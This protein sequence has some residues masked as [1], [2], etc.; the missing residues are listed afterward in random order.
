MKFSFVLPAWKGK[1]L[2]EAI[3]SILS[4]TC[5][6]FELIVV[7]DCS[8]DPIKDI[9]DCFHDPRVSYHRN[10]RNIGGTDLVAQWM[11]CL[12]Y[13]H[14]D[15]VI[16]ATDDDL[17]EPGFLASME[18]LI[19][20]Y[21]QVHLFRSRM[22]TIGADGHIQFLDDCFKEFLTTDEFVYHLFHGMIRG[23][24][25]YVFH[26]KALLEK[27][28]FVNFPL[29]WGSDDATAILMADH[30][31]VNNQDNLVRFRWSDVN[32]SS[33]SKSMPRKIE[34][35]LQY[36]VW[37]RRHLRPI[38]TDTEYNR[39]LHRNIDDYWHQVVKIDL[40]TFLR[41]AFW[42]DKAACL[43]LICASPELSRH[44]KLSI[45]YHAFFYFRISRW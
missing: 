41:K 25:H 8:P 31:V 28:G 45:I 11:R 13:A 30:G 24:P 26:R 15:Y 23:I 22:M 43:R 4:Q 37:L 34:A 18:P 40:I 29:A 9:V 3:A 19:E 27:G 35:R 10:E 6:D 38:P 33:D 20:K 17:Y 21:P 36:H 32:I 16:L 44:D 7:D 39:F 5:S 2:K 14:A 12:S 1:Y 42:R